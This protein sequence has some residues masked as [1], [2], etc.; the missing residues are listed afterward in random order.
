MKARRASSQVASQR[1]LTPSGDP[2][3][4]IEVISTGTTKTVMPF[5]ATS[6]Q[7]GTSQDVKAMVQDMV[8][9]SL[10][11]LGVIPQDTPTQSQSQYCG[12]GPSQIEDIS[13][14]EIFNSDQEAS[15]YDYNYDYDSFLSPTVT[16]APLWRFAE[17]TPSGSQTLCL[18]LRLQPLRLST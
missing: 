11:Q 9:S 1:S 10:T 13:E 7:D 2:P 15:D 3:S 16:K 18:N 5:P 17:Q 14:G 12:S 4:G 8:K 6:P